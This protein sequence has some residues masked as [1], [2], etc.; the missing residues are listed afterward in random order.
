MKVLPIITAAAVLGLALPAM[1]QDLT[2]GPGVSTGTG[3]TVAPSIEVPAPTSLSNVTKISVFSA[4]NTDGLQ[5]QTDP[6]LATNP[7][8]AEAIQ[9]AGYGGSQILGYNLDGT[10]LTVYVKST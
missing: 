8:V 9:K 1:A 2:S 6:T 5:L 10:S 3:V 7:Q 4:S